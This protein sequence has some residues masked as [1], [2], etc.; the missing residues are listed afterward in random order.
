MKMPPTT[1]VTEEDIKEFF[2]EAKEGV[3]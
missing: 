1:S 3:S 2:A